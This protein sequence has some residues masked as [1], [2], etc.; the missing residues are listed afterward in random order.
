MKTY[1]FTKELTGWGDTKE[2]AWESMKWFEQPFAEMPPD[3]DIRSFEN[4]E[5]PEEEEEEL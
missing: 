4:L 1:I 3:K 5:Q 2:E